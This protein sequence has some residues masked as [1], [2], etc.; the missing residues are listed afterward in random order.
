MHKYKIISIDMSENESYVKNVYGKKLLVLIIQKY[1]WI[2]KYT[3]VQLFQNR[4]E[5][6]IYS[7]YPLVVL[8]GSLS[9]LPLL[10]RVGLEDFPLPL[11]VGLDVLPLPSFGV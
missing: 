2:K 10:L 6:R 8:E 7:I 4:T 3:C 5:W 9:Y 11:R 1:E